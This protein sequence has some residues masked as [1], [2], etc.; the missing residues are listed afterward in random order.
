MRTLP[1]TVFALLL[2]GCV[3]T[4][5]HPR[6]VEDDSHM[7]TSSGAPCIAAYVRPDTPLATDLS[8]LPIPAACTS[9]ADAAML[10][11][12]GVAAATNS[13]IDTINAHAV[14]ATVWRTGRA[15]PDMGH[16]LASQK[17][18]EV[19]GARLLPAPDRA[20]IAGRAIALDTL[21]LPD[22]NGWFSVICVYATDLSAG[23]AGAQICRVASDMTE[24]SALAIAAAIVATDLPALRW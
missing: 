5:G 11:A 23:T 17:L 10:H 18:A 19:P 15:A 22:A 1:M 12:S 7:V 8:A 14:S 20:V 3:G 2:S 24:R 21:A 4:G 6:P 16:A 9:G 13:S